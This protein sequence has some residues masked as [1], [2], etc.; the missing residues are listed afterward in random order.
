MRSRLSSASESWPGI[1]AAYV[2]VNVL[3]WLVWLF[4]D[5]STNGSI[6]WPAWVTLAWGFFL[7][8]DGW[9]AYGRWPA[10][11]PITETE[12][13]HESS[14]GSES[15]EREVDGGKDLPQE[16]RNAADQLALPDSHPVSASGP[17]YLHIL[18]ESRA[19]TEDWPPLLDAGRRSRTRWPAVA[20]QPAYGPVSW[21]ANARA[22]GEVTLSRGGRSHQFEVEEA[23]STAAVPVLRN[24]ITEIR[25]TR[26]YFDAGPSSTDEEHADRSPE[27]PSP[28]VSSPR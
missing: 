23:A 11:K 13:E 7:A 10:N 3:L 6:P 21:V 27:A 16:P 22:A 12:I 24:Y 2:A 17:P 9:R 28:P 4:T 1:R 26:P 19:G 20:G 18:T 15:S 8:L 14:S 5:P 25:V